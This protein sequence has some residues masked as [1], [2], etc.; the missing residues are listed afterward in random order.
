MDRNHLNHKVGSK[1][2]VNNQQHPK[3]VDNQE[4]NGSQQL[5]DTSAQDSVS[6]T[7]KFVKSAKTHRESEKE[8]EEDKERDNQSMKEDPNSDL[9]RR[10]E[11][12]DARCG[13][14]KK[15]KYI[16]IYWLSASNIDQLQS[17]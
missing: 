9:F 3:D 5:E 14:V 16:Y 2:L 11:L 8:E 17:Y 4:V 15:K 13:E 6:Q 12:H 1:D 10:R 7:V